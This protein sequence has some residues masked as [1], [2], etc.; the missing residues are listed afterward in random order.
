MVISG[1]R[2]KPAGW[3]TREDFAVPP[4]TEGYNYLCILR[5]YSCGVNMGNSQLEILSGW[6]QIAHHLGKGVRTVQRYERELGLPIRRP[7]GKSGGSVIATAGELDAWVTASP[8][9]EQFELAR[10]VINTDMLE[11]LRRNVKEMVR[12]RK[13]THEVRSAVSESLEL[14]RKNILFATLDAQ[15]SHESAHRVRAEVLSFNT[16]RKKAH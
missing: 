5:Q 4:A 6:K 1:G 15:A 12:L 11:Q 3:D 9:G 13:E 14:L 16:K 8:I 10:T 7:A 2:S